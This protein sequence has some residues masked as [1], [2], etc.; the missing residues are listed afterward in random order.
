MQAENLAFFNPIQV[1]NN[2]CT[3]NIFWVN[4]KSKQ[5]YQYFVDTV[6]FDTTNKKTKYI[7]SFVMFRGVNHYL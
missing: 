5:A 1:D 3:T 7:M 2:N 4:V 6:T